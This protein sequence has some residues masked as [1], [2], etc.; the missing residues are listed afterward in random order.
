MQSLAFLGKSQT[1]IS[2][3]HSSSQI[4]S[5]PKQK[6]NCTTQPHQT[7]AIRP[8]L[9]AD[10]GSRSVFQMRSQFDEIVTQPKNLRLRNK[11]LSID[12]G[13]AC[14]LCASPSSA[15]PTHLSLSFAQASR[16]LTNLIPGIKGLES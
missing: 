10:F 16:E 12:S 5:L 7:Q 14:F 9:K 3:K 6:T 8:H 13:K 2:K 1:F 4:Y 15:Y 11:K